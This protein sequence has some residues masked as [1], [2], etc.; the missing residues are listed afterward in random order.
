VIYEKRQERGE[1]IL[2]TPRC[3][4]QT[5]YPGRL[6]SGLTASSASGGLTRCGRR[7][8]PKVKVHSLRWSK[9]TSHSRLR[10][11]REA[12]I[13]QRKDLILCTTSLSYRWE[14][15]YPALHLRSLWSETEANPRSKVRLRRLG[16]VTRESLLFASFRV[17]RALST[18]PLWP[19]KSTLHRAVAH[20]NN[21][22]RSSSL[23]QTQTLSV[24]QSLGHRN[25]DS[26]PTA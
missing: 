11:S 14:G 12:V 7:S 2:Y 26:T 22:V 20:S 8:R 17:K 24:R 19:I 21:H 13:T 6:R 25:D 3:E 9:D 15:E 18:M 10:L 23:A 5:I 1:R 16:D 4:A